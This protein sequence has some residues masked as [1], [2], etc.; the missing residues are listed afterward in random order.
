MSRLVFCESALQKFYGYS[1]DLQ[2][3]MMVITFHVCHYILGPRQFSSQNNLHITDRTSIDN[4]ETN[5]NKTF[6]QKCQKHLILRL[7]WWRLYNNAVSKELFKVELT[8]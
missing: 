1:V 2:F 8:I 4:G 7:S 3:L 5:L 6:I